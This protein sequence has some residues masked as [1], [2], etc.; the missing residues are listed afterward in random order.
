MRAALADLL[1]RGL[2][3]LPGA[4]NVYAQRD[5]LERAVGERESRVQALEAALRAVPPPAPPPPAPPPPAPPPPAP[6][7]PA[8]PPPAPP[9]PAPPPAPVAPSRPTERFA[10][11]LDASGVGAPA[12]VLLR[13]VQDGPLGAAGAP[14][15]LP[16]DET[17]Y[18]VILR[19]GV[20][21]AEE[22][23]FIRRRVDPARRYALVDVGANVG[24][25][26]RQA[27]RAIAGIDRIVCI[28]A[29]PGNFAALCHNLA[30]L[31]PGVCALHNVAL[32]DRAGTMTWYRDSGNFGNYSLNADAMRGQAFTTVSV[33]AVE[34]EAFFATMAALPDD[35]RVIWKS[36]TQG[37]DEAI[38][39]R[40]PLALW[41]RVDLAILELWRIAKPDFDRDAFRDRL[42]AFP[43]LSI[44]IDR[45]ASVED[46]MAYLA[47]GDYG[48]EDLYL[49][50]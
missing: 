42:A 9:P 1:H 3:R 46:V 16:Y 4:R 35:A 48:F 13:L 26:S 14:L 21:Q 20:W 47:G 45:P 44:G 25:F 5:A 34:T 49:W 38:L 7:P 12:G 37:Y 43:H 40:V 22:L 23:D 18:P 28:E 41:E 17:M 50:R 2:R 31:P 11:M 32:A 15:L 19:N 8:P 39:A 10:A 27:Q 24:L 36:D 33:T 6:P 29:D 30:H